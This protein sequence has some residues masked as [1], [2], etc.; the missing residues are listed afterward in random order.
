MTANSW[1]ANAKPGGP[2]QWLE[3]AM[4]EAFSLRGLAL[5][6]D[7]WSVGVTAHLAGSTESK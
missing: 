1:R 2:C 3:E 5:L 4:V 6:A 7:S